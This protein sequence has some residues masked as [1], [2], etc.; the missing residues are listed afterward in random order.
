[1]VFCARPT[2]QRREL[3]LG[4]VVQW[5]E[6]HR[7]KVGVGGSS[8][9]RATTYD[10]V[11]GMSESVNKKL[12]HI[13]HQLESLNRIEAGL[14][15]VVKKENKEIA[16]IEK[17][18]MLIER[19]LLKIGNFTLKRSHLLELARGTAG[20]FLGV[21]VG[22]ALGISVT[23]AKKIPWPNALGLLIFIVLLVGILIYKNDKAAMAGTRKHPMRYISERILQLYAI[24]W[25]VELIGLI[26][27][28]NFPGWNG[29]LVK[30]L[31]VGSF[32]A[33]SSAAAFSIL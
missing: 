26:L 11:Y 27:F 4:P 25:A 29:L 30:T 15:N 33:M 3:R 5:I 18:E 22:Q 9:S 32:P 17:E 13:E 16:E 28:N 2:R 12:T 31:V 7:P 21:G 8:P 19:N 10:N 24:S 6:H 23:L 20:A 1:M 14:E